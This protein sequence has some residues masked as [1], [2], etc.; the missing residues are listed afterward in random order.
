[1]AHLGV[2]YRRS[3]AETV[4]KDFSSALSQLRETVRAAKDSYVYGFGE[5]EVNRT[6][7]NCIRE[8]LQRLFTLGKVGAIVQQQQQ[9]SQRQR[10]SLF[11][12]TSSQ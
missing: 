8:D 7:I 9:Q 4:L 5:M 10:K 11:N 2:D 12:F 1:M 6:K 3:I